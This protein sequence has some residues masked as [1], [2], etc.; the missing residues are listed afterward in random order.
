LVV[1]VWMH[2]FMVCMIHPCSLINSD[3]PLF[4]CHLNK[5]GFPW[6]YLSGTSS[7][8]NILMCS[9]FCFFKRCAG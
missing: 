8:E 7:D 9:S 4:S 2:C 6:S 1:I 3:V 5:N